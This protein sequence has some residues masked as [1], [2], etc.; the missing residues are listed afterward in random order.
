MNGEN[1]MRKQTKKRIIDNYISEFSFATTG[2]NFRLIFA[3]EG[4]ERFITKEEEAA[5]ILEQERGGFFVDKY[6][7]FVEDDRTDDEILSEC[8]PMDNYEASNYALYKNDNNSFILFNSFCIAENEDEKLEDIDY[9]INFADI[10]LGEYI[11]SHN[12]CIVCVSKLY[13]TTPD[14]VVIEDKE[15]NEGFG[16]GDDPYK[17]LSQIR[18]YKSNSYENIGSDDIPWKFARIVNGIRSKYVPNKKIVF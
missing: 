8:P 2:E 11:L 12:N 7:N 4:V 1:I 15:L 6:G 10:N 18:E 14:F 3:G 17:I 16:D 5:N 9:L 13:G